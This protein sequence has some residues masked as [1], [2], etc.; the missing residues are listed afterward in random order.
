MLSAVKSCLGHARAFAPGAMAL[1]LALATADAQ[2][3]LNR[4]L[5]Q[6]RVQSASDVTF[7]LL[8]RAP[9]ESSYVALRTRR[10]LGGNGGLVEVREQLTIEGDGTADSSF[11]LAFVDIPGG[12]IDPVA[13][14]RWD[15]TYRTNAGLLHKHG[16]FLVRDPIAAARNY[17]IFDFGLAQRAGREVRRVVVFPL[18]MDKGIWVVDVDTWTGTV[19]YSAEFDTGLRLLNELE[20]TV[21]TPIRA[22]KNGTVLTPGQTVS[23][24]PQPKLW[25]WQPRMTVTRFPTIDD[26]AQAV[27]DA[28]LLSPKIQDIVTEYT[29]S[30]CQLTEDP[31]NGDRTL[32][33][34]Y[35]D[36]VDE[37]FVLQTF[38][39]QD[40]F[41][42]IWA[43]VRNVPSG[44]RTHAIASYDDPAL[45]AYVFFEKGTLYQ[46][47]GRG[48]LLRL[49]DVSL[50]LCQQAV[51][52]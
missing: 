11:D 1:V 12:V 32:V 10:F 14:A 39:G 47:S 37:F 46:V 3:L 4:A 2:G 35:S 52:D 18:R 45:R 19:L 48:S 17:G 33:L 13:S 50:R 43:N 40:P 24:T 36:G 16:C 21:F 41:R 15:N 27:P 42:N 25:G 5:P 23:T 26:V 6:K 7:D 9:F 44:P 51:R 38:G 31:V 49:K 28:K 29:Q 34:G 30:L 8:A 20:T 22:L